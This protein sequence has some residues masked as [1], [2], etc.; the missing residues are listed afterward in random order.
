MGSRWISGAAIPALSATEGSSLAAKTS[1]PSGSGP[2]AK[3][4]RDHHPDQLADR[5]HLQLEPN[6]D[7]DER[8]LG[9][10]CRRWIS[11]QAPSATTTT[12]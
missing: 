6:G 9:H 3:G 2:V 7:I 11:G 8:A 1:P 5:R 10:G 12:T 4:G